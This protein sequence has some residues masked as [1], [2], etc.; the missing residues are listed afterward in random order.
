MAK[1]ATCL[2]GF[3]LALASMALATT[4]EPERRV[5]VQADP[6]N[7]C[8]ADPECVDLVAHYTTLAV[9]SGLYEE[10][11]FVL[12]TGNWTN[13]THTD[14]NPLARRQLRGTKENNEHEF[15]ERLLEEIPEHR[16]LSCSQCIPQYGS[17]QMC[18]F[19]FGP[20]CRNF[21]RLEEGN[22]DALIEEIRDTCYSDV[23]IDYD[24]WVLTVMQWLAEMHNAHE[25]IQGITY[26]VQQ[27][28]VNR[29]CSP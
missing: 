14:E 24:V 13:G 22:D 10:G 23:G 3:L 18:I 17:A 5:L 28:R 8:L 16:R 19:F 21:R 12:N 6:T 7:T 4:E 9:N 15:D 29:R 27:R 26:R 25:V 2:I 20:G 1:I 11:W